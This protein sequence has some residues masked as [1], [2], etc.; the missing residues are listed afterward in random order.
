MST[1]TTN[2]NGNATAQATDA[3]T[4]LAETAKKGSKK[5]SETIPATET[6]ES[7]NNWEELDYAAVESINQA[8]LIMVGERVDHTE[9]VKGLCAVGRVELQVGQKRLSFGTMTKETLKI[10]P[11]TMSFLFECGF[12]SEQILEVAADAKKQ[13][14]LGDKVTKAKDKATRDRAKKESKIERQK[15]ILAKLNGAN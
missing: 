12:S 9:N 14:C 10:D 3:K 13:W 1:A 11:V 7:T 15:A 6:E 8:M 4:L 5:K 2:G